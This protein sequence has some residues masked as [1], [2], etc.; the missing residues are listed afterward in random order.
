MSEL[1]TTVTAK[2]SVDFNCDIA[3][4]FSID[5]NE[6][7]LSL[8]NYMSSVNI[9]C[10]FHAG[11]PITMKKAIEYCKH[12][13]KVIG[14]HIGFP[15]IQ[16][17]G[18]RPMEMDEDE[19]EAIVLYQLGAVA[20]FAK[21]Y[22]LAIEHVRPHGAMYK[23]ASQNVKFGT[24]LAKA[25]K[26][27][28]NWLV[29]YGAAGAVIETVASDANI[30]IARELQLDKVYTSA[31]EIDYS[32]PAI[33][34]T[35]KSSIRLRRLVNLSEIDNENQD[36]TKIEFDTIHFSNTP[37]NSLELAQAAVKIITPTPVNYNRAEESGWV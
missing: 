21:A 25:V 29:Y 3:Q 12:K 11:D 13:D 17:F 18:Y 7:D 23:L 34:D 16:G 9:S 5:K 15:D 36:Y 1:S 37:A 19:I 8:I 27:F 35:G 10:G 20:S 22:G 26:K 14:A 28:S 24:S 2:K 6:T 33:E 4:S 31:G 30:S 32:Q